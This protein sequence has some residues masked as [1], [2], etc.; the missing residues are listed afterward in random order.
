MILAMGDPRL[1]SKREIETGGMLDDLDDDSPSQY[2]YECQDLSTKCTMMTVEGESP[3]NPLM[4][5][6]IWAKGPHQVFLKKQLTPYAHKCA[7]RPKQAA[8]FIAMVVNEWFIIFHWCLLLGWEPQ[9]TDIVLDNELL[10]DEELDA[11]LRLSLSLAHGGSALML[12]K[13]KI[14]Q[15]PIAAFLQQL[16]VKEPMRQWA[17]MAQQ[18]W[19]KEHLVRPMKVH[20]EQEFEASNRLNNHHTAVQAEFVGNQFGELSEEDRKLWKAKAQEDVKN[21][22][23]GKEEIVPGPSLLPPEEAQKAIDNIGMILLPLAESIVKSLGMQVHIVLAGPEPCKGSQL[24]IIGIHEG[25]DKSVILRWFDA[26]GGERGTESDEDE[27]DVDDKEQGLDKKKKKTGRKKA[28]TLKEKVAAK[29]KPS[30]GKQAKTKATAKENKV[31]AGREHATGGLFP[32]ADVNEK[33]GRLQKRQEVPCQG[34]SF[35]TVDPTTVP[36]LTSAGASAILP[37][38]VEEHALIA[39]YMDP[40]NWLPWFRQA[41]QYLGRFKLGKEWDELL[42]L[43]TILERQRRDPKKLGPISAYSA[44]WWAWWHRLQL[45]WRDS[46]GEGAFQGDGIIVENSWLE[47]KNPM[48]GVNA[49]SCTAT[50]YFGHLAHFECQLQ[51]QLNFPDLCSLGGLEKK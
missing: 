36:T 11:K 49:G 4:I 2:Q 23:H 40:M 3:E 33:G 30:R 32:G 45:E 31:P 29:S 42:L 39:D 26:A 43:F 7:L 13:K 47:L 8:E 51:M 12:T 22:K 6:L 9:T 41:H 15:D 46:P 38:G 5:L 34:P 17:L 16:T 50:S 24:N 27:D 10:T 37:G 44:G 48:L 19:L 18:L 20:F 21:V 28:S 25:Y 14:T 35:Q 1:S